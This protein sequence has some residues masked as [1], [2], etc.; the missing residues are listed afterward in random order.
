MG[1]NWEERRE[2]GE[3]QKNNNKNVFCTSCVGVTKNW[4]LTVIFIG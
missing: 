3:T 2:R 1:R 4:T